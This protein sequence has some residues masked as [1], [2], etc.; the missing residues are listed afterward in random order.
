MGPQEDSKTPTRTSHL[1]QI[2]HVQVWTARPF[3]EVVR[4]VEAETGVFDGATIQA[5][6]EAKAPPSSV[7]EVIAAM[8]GRSGFMRFAALDHGAILR[9]QG[10][11]TEA[12]R[13]LIGHPLTASRM[14]VLQIGS[15]LYAPLSLLVAADRR[16]GTRLE[17]DRPSTLFS[18]FEDPG[19]AKVAQELDDELAALIRAVTGVS[20]G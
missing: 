17:Y 14:T 10:K 2:E 7:L 1:V 3:A 6:I 12:V 19:V 11:P 20:G 5:R 15:A 18:Q 13:F 16:G 4:G 8:A 9:L